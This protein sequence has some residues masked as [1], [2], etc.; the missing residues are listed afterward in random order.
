MVTDNMVSP[1][2]V[3]AAVL[4]KQGTMP[5]DHFC[6][7]TKVYEMRFCVQSSVYKELDS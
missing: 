3:V 5:F 4:P 1:T 2:D 6:Q 7:M